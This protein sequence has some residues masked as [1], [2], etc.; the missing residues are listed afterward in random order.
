MDRSLPPD[1]EFLHR[2]LIPIRFLIWQLRTSYLINNKDG[3]GERLIS[4]PSTALFS[5]P[6]IKNAGYGAH[7]ESQRTYSPP[8]PVTTTVASEYFSGPSKTN[9]FDVNAGDGGGG[10]VTGKGSVDTVGPAPQVKRRRRREQQEEDDSSDLSD[11]SD[12]TEET[13]V[14]VI[15]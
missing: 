11:E 9:S 8:I 15:S 13:C 7:L 1:F 6:S 10:M 12:D 5:D 14:P 4:L 2:M 3:V